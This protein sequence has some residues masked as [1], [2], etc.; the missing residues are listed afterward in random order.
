M[1]VA[2]CDGKAGAKRE[3]IRQK[4]S[5]RPLNGSGLNLL[6]S[7]QLSILSETVRAM[8]QQIGHTC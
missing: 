5:T 3:E 7:P 4:G 2:G 6:D 1:V 8:F